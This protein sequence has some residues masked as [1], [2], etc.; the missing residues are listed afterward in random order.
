[1][2]V[3]VLQFDVMLPYGIDVALISTLRLPTELNLLN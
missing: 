1:M 3:Y 2:I